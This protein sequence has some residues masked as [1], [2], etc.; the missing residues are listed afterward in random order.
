MSFFHWRALTLLTMFLLFQGCRGKAE[1]ESSSGLRANKSCVIALA[2][3]SSAMN[4]EVRGIDAEILRLQKKAGSDSR[5][6]AHIEQIGWR[7]VEKARTAYDPGYYK[8]AEQCASCLESI[9]PGSVDAM[10][11]RGHIYHSLHRFK[12]AEKIATRL[13]ARRGRA[14]DYGL[15][16]DVL[17]EQGKLDQAVDAYQKMIDQKPNLQSYSRAAHL[18]WLKGDLEGATEL[19]KMAVSAASPADPESAAWAYTRLSQYQFQAGRRAEARQ[20]CE[21]A[22][23]IRRDYVP[24]LAACS[25]VLIADNDLTTAVSL[26]KKAAELD[27]LPEYQW[28][29][30]D[31]LLAAGKNEEASEV[32]ERIE[33]TGE[34]ADPRTYALYLATRGRRPDEALRLARNEMGNRS[35]VF[36]WDALAWAES[37]T[38]RYEDAYRNIRK[39]LAEGTVDARLYLH[40]A[41]IA[42]NA[43][44]RR[45]A[46]K[47]AAMASGI[48]H[49]LLPGERAM[50]RSLRYN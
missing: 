40:A 49:T 26:L 18:R 5:P 46:A 41:V 39:A 47:Y 11:L 28:A 17:M 2:K 35:D 30:A 6:A 14:F 25:R 20:A 23:S 50:L 12:E 16:G 48:A 22:V 43:G 9:D 38:G 37:A 29:L 24:G 33:G 44:D 15:L 31:A 4:Q 8:I 21:A 13:V 10:L 3:T 27:P 32:E 1:P 36:S 45:E 34:K 42:S 7:Y 19:M